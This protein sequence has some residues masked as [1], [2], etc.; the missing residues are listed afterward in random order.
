MSLFYSR[1]L[2]LTAALYLLAVLLY[3]ISPKTANYVHPWTCYL[4]AF[5]AG[6]T[7]LQH[8]LTIGTLK[9]SPSGFVRMYMGI[10]ALKM[11]ILIGLFL[12]LILHGIY[13]PKLFAA[14]FLL[15]YFSYTMLEAFTLSKELRKTN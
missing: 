2:G 5:F 3:Y 7:L 4:P 8:R 10:T 11:F 6:I 9:G 15:T 14:W 1:L 13:R 12:A